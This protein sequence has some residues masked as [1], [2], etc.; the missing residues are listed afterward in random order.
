MRLPHGEDPRD[1]V[2]R[3][4]DRMGATYASW[5]QESHD[6]AREEHTA[7]LLDALPPGSPVLD[8]GCGAGLPTTR[9]LAE[10][11]D[12]LGV[13]ISFE[14]L[15]RARRNVPRAAFVQADMAELNLAPGSVAAVAAFYSI[16]H[17]PR[18]E[19]A[20]L[21]GRIRCWLKPDGL[22][23]V[24][25]GVGAD[26]GTVDAFFDQPMYWSSY[27]AEAYLR[28]VAEAGLEVQSAVHRQVD[29]F[30][31]PVTFLWMLARAPA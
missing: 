10:H 31:S 13:D 6:P 24:T 2:A 14:Q 3:G 28:T 1:V 9:T 30:G 12:V 15:V 21:L 26:P 16:I 4:Y 20:A 7:L 18:E 8:L 23:V 25:L 5:A 19:Q 29:E 27:D 22:L 11:L 17:V